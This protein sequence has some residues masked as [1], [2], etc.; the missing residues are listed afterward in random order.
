MTGIQTGPLGSIGANAVSPAL[1]NGIGSPSLSLG[2]GQSALPQ[3]SAVS[4]ISRTEATPASVAARPGAAA[5]LGPS[6]VA[7][8]EAEGLGAHGRSVSLRLGR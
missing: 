7:L 6:A 8:A 4:P 1:S 5:A 2:L 3:V